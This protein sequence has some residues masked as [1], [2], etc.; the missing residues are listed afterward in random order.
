MTIYG[1]S[2]NK[3]LYINKSTKYILYT[4]LQENP[5][6]QFTP[7][8][9]PYF[10][11]PKRT[12]ACN[13]SVNCAPIYR[14]LQFT[15]HFSVPPID[16]VNQENIINIS[17]SEFL[18]LYKLTELCNILLQIDFF[19]NP[20]YL[21]NLYLK[22]G[23]Q[24]LSPMKKLK[25]KLCFPSITANFLTPPPLFIWKNPWKFCPHLKGGRSCGMYV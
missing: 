8:Y 17:A 20:I 10:L 6:L 19:F 15:V 9:R 2:T 16:A 4:E 5:D 12:H 21:Y 25:C 14:L 13:L 18:V 7:T 22:D 23:P 11:S 24:I 1:Q 3:I